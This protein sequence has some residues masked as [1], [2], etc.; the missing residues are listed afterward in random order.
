M[1]V[2]IMRV[3]IIQVV[4]TEDFYVYAYFE[5]GKITKFN[6]KPFLSGPAFRP[7]SDA[8]TF[9]E[10]ATII[11]DTLAWDLQGNRNDTKCLD[12]AYERVYDAPTVDE[13]EVIAYVRKH[14]ERYVLPDEE[15]M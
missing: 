9:V 3:P 12:I 8:K 1:E 11:N 10:T 15:D 5:D 2:I 4:P 7:I 14:P 6:M 13:S